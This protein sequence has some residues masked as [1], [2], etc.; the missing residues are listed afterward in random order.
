MINQNNLTWESSWWGNCANTLGEELKQLQYAKGMGLKFHHN[1]KSPYFIDMQGKSVLDIG[2]GPCSLLLK[3]ENLGYNL[4]LDPCEYPQWVYNRYTCANINYIKMSGEEFVSTDNFDECLIYNVLQ[5]TDNPEL[6]LSNAKKVSK[7]IRIFEWVD[8]GVS[9]GHP[10]DLK[11]EL[12]NK[13]LGGIGKVE[14]INTN[15]CKGKCYFGV[16]KG[17][18][19]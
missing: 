1:G 18:L 4:V 6:I 15:E 17:D 10:Q 11:E 9:E 16:F 19:Y 12:L 2:G 14:Y 5:H 3:C 13:W 7:I 8:N